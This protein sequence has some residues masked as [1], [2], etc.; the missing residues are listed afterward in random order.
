MKPERAFQ[1]AERVQHSLLTPLE[2]RILPWIAARLPSW[3]NSDHLTL[4]GF[5][6]LIS[7]GA[8]YWYA[9]GSRAGL[10]LA[11]LFLIL[12]W[13]GDSL[14]GTLARVRN[15][16]RPRYGFYVDHI[17][18]ACGSVFVFGGLAL[19]GYMDARVAAALLVAY[20]LLSAESYLA[21]YTVGTFHLSF[22]A[23]GPTELRVLLITGNLALWLNPNKSLFNVGGMIGVAGMVLALLWSIARHT[24]QLYRAEPL[25]PGPVRNWRPIVRRWWRFN[26]V[27][28][29]GFALQLGVLWI[30]ARIC[31]VHYLI[32]TALA[33]EIAVL[34]NFAWHEAWTWRS[35]STE[36][37]WRRLLRFNLANGF[38]SI[39]SNLLFTL[40]FM[41]W[42]GLPLLAANTAAVIM[43]ALLNFALAESWVFARPGNV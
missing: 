20:L 17:L 38:V 26:L 30:L 4:L 40:L 16:Q 21:T 6:S 41:Q 19:S 35:V 9:H 2:R 5:L 34:H 13:F 24:L 27:G 10:L 25:P 39:A 18:D 32:A 36:G 12:N 22:A 1:T 11:N 31:G 37:R 43:M 8:S 23:V 14:D 29:G 3:I 15:R 42:M 28:I 7:V 33:V